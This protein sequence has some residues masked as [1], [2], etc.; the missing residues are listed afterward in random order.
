M[1]VIGVDP[2]TEESA[3]VVY[4]VSTREVHQHGIYE[5]EA[6]IALFR[7]PPDWLAGHVFIFEQIY[8]GGMPA[9]IET[10]ETVFWTGRFAEAL[11]GRFAWTR[12]KRV[13][14]KMTLCHNTRANDAAIRQALLDRFG[15]GKKAA[16]GNKKSPGPLYGLKSHE[17]AA[18]ALAVTWADRCVDGHAAAAEAPAFSS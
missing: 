4:D 10:F 7:H 5:N 12:Y 2:G 16:I 9:G 6:L 13:L 18:L 14:V 3:I 8:M 17:W 11:Q 15:G 1:K